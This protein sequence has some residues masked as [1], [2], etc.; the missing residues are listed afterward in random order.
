MDV[1][2]LR[3]RIQTERAEPRSAGL[4]YGS[5]VSLKHR[6]VASTVPKAGCSTLKLA[7]H[8]FET[9]EIEL[10]G[11]WRV[12]DDW[13]GRQLLSH[14]T[15]AIVEMLT[16]PD[17]LRF[18]IVRNPY[19]RLL[20]AWKSKLG[21]DGDK[22]YAALRA[23]I[24]EAFDYPVVDGKRVGVVA[25]RDAVTH[26]ITRHPTNPFDDHW[27][28]MV[29]VMCPDVIDYDVIGRFENFAADLRS[30]LERLHAPPDVV[31]IADQIHNPTYKSPLAE[32][33][34][35]ALADQVY[36]F[37]EAD[38]ELFGYSKDSWRFI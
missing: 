31:A 17:W 27:T 30:I 7:L 24:R 5:R 14:P 25:F 37:Y 1:A 29:G 15:D 8:R 16:S 23:E 6:Y 21:P 12:H 4:S 18:A 13:E 38:F 11:W 19:D 36:D 28:P 9:P 2:E 22:N 26:M 3:Q 34:D 20:S 32:A 35:K 33:Y 10:E